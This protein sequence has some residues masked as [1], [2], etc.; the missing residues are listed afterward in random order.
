M[1]IIVM[2]CCFSLCMIVNRCL[3][4]VGVSV[5]VGLLRIRMCVLSDSVL[6]ILMNCCCVIDSVWIGVLRLIV[7]FR[8][9]KMVVVVVCICLWLCVF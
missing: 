7:M 2:F 1:K 6:L 5:V 4:L 3:V 8:C 9:V